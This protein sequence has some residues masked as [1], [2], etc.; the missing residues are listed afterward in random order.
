M[1]PC[2]TFIGLR[3]PLV[4]PLMLSVRLI[5]WPKK[6]SR[7]HL[8]LWAYMP[9][10]LSEDSSNLHVEL[11]G[12]L[13]P[14]PWPP[15]NPLD[16]PFDPLFSKHIIWILRSKSIINSWTCQS[17]SV[18]VYNPNI[19]VK[20]VSIFQVKTIR[21]NNSGDTHWNHALVVAK[22][23]LIMGETTSV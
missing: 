2:I 18:L 5:V 11:L 14:P 4:L 10:E 15:R 3:R 13:R 17:H 7:S 6:K 16:T 1:A 19:Y 8:Y 23:F 21:S 9:C 22:I 12:F 20:N